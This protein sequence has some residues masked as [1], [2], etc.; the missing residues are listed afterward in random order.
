MSSEYAATRVLTKRQVFMHDADRRDLRSDRS[1]ASSV[2][3]TRAGFSVRALALAF[4][5]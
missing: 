4:P 1:G 5:R 3:A 2:L